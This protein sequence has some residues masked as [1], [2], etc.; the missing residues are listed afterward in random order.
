MQPITEK[1]SYYVDYDY[2]QQCVVCYKRTTFITDMLD[3]NTEKNKYYL[4]EFKHS[5]YFSEIDFRSIIPMHQ[6]ILDS[7]RDL[8]SNVFLLLSNTHEAFTDVVLPIYL[9]VIEKY[10]IPEEKVILYTE[11]IDIEN[12][13]REVAE[14]IKRKPFKVFLTSGFEYSMQCDLDFF[15]NNGSARLPKTLNRIK[16]KKKFLY[17]N[18]RWRVHRPITVALMKLSGLLN[19]G[20]V[21][22]GK[23]DHVDTWEES[24]NNMI[25]C[26]DSPVR[27][28]FLTNKEKIFNIPEMYLDTTKLFENQAHLDVT[29]T[30]DYY[31]T[32]M[33]SVVS[34]TNYFTN[35]GEGRFISEKTFKPIAFKHP[36][37]MISVPGTLQSLRALGYK[38]FHPMIDESYDTITDHT[39]RLMAII[40]EIDRLCSLTDK[41]IAEF[42]KFCKPIVN[43]NYELLLDKKQFVHKII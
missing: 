14:K 28:F 27:Q 18:R 1:A 8:N 35:N 10:D 4:I 5:K 33:F 36:F 39:V 6:H 23:T 21:S 26:I 30:A 7:I 43:Y 17:F 25:Y 11:S 24:W 19:Q 40:R 20:Y 37:V 29:G 16:Y 12:Y 31:S 38:T 13:V 9:H 2:A 34:E 22:L 42:N 3:Y 41:Q 15:I 32:S